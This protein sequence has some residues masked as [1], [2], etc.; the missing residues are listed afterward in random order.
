M[1]LFEAAGNHFQDD[2]RNILT[3]LQGRANSASQAELIPW[4]AVNRMLHNQGYADIDV[5]II[6]QIRDQLDPAA[7][8]IQSTDPK[9]IVL[10]TSNPSP[11]PS[12]DAPTGGT[13]SMAQMSHNVV[14]RNRGF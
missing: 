6:D 3:V 8:L 14:K 13:K 5:D 12:V 7:E 9:G 2:L 4:G 10:K 1:R 11:E